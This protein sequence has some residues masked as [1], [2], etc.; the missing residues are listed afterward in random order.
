MSNPKTDIMFEPISPAYYGGS[1]G[2]HSKWSDVCYEDSVKYVVGIDACNKLNRNHKL[3]SS[4]AL[5][6]RQRLRNKLESIKRK[7]VN[8]N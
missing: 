6:V 3:Q 8:E 1:H 2:S 7:I 5:T 4:R